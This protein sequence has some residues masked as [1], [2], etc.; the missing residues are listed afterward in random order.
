MFFFLKK[1]KQYIY[2]LT[3]IKSIIIL[4]IKNISNTEI[5]TYWTTHAVKKKKQEEEEEKRPV[6]SLEGRHRCRSISALPASLAV[7]L[8]WN[9]LLLSHYLK[10]TFYVKLKSCIFYYIFN[11]L[12]RFKNNNNNNLWNACN[13]IA[14]ACSKY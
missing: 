6:W 9:N 12:S 11:W 8:L 13:I 1:A 4:C 14:Q 3:E 10:T 5:F 2:I 7:W